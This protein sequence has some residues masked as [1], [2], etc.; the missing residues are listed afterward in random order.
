MMS[1]YAGFSQKSLVLGLLLVV[2]LLVFLMMSVLLKAA[3]NSPLARI[4]AVRFLPGIVF[5]SIGVFYFF[6]LV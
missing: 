3:A 6:E 4:P 5:I 2:T 1:H